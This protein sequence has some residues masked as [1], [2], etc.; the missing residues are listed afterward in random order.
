MAAAAAGRQAG[1]RAA[2]RPTHGC[3]TT[4]THLDG[5]G[6][7]AARQ[8]AA[9]V[10]VEDADRGAHTHR[11][12]GHGGH[13]QPQLPCCRGC[14]R[15]LSRGGERRAAAQALS[16]CHTVSTPP[17][18]SQPVSQPATPAG[19]ASPS[20]PMSRL[21]A[22]QRIPLPPPPRCLT[23]ATASPAHTISAHHHHH[24]HHPSIHHLRHHHHSPRPRT[25]GQRG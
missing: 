4:H 10:V 2:A 24:H 8:G 12:L 14:R 5:E 22:R 18:P 11:A 6:V 20:P 16:P 7:A 21:P 13:L 9:A 23:S 19:S 17:Q 25:R 1:R 15:H 3:C